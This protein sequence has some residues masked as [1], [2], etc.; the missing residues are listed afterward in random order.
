MS[1][2]SSLI[3]ESYFVEDINDSS[4]KLSFVG[5]QSQ[6]AWSR[7]PNSKT[8]PDSFEFV[9]PTPNR[10]VSRSP[11]SS[12]KLK[13][14]GTCHTGTENISTSCTTSHTVPHLTTQ[15]ESHPE[16]PTLEE[17]SSDTVHKVG[18]LP[19][20]P[21]GDYVENIHPILD[22]NQTRYPD[23]PTSARLS[24]TSLDNEAFQYHPGTKAKTP[25]PIDFSEEEASA[26][27]PSFSDYSLSRKDSP[28]II[29]TSTPPKTLKRIVDS[30]RPRQLSGPRHL[31]SSEERQDLGDEFEPPLESAE[32]LE[33]P[34][35]RDS[36]QHRKTSSGFSSTFVGAR[37]SATTDLSSSSGY[38]SSQKTHW[39]RLSRFSKR[40]S[41]LSDTADRAS[42][43]SNCGPS[44][45][46]LKAT[47]DRALQRRR[48]IG[49]LTSSESEYLNDLGILTY[50]CIITQRLR[51]MSLRLFRCTSPSLALPRHLTGIG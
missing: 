14:S 18:Q 30:V 19:Y 15:K 8:F 47:V 12:F 38:I 48:I 33:V 49:E 7:N 9:Y 32:H 39:S 28:C 6:N 10:E 13:T 20:L 1:R 45:S 23:A 16:E 36:G 4:G 2:V 42:M 25:G 31:K 43:D 51:A 3:D 21:Y 29:I 17:P 27:I 11:A 22:A 35:Q 44:P 5:P 34:P 41:R 26:E 24:I 46:P 37:N 50:V 40:S